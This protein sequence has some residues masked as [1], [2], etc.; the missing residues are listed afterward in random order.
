M[1]MDSNSVDRV[2]ASCASVG[3][4]PIFS[5]ASTVTLDRHRSDPNLNGAVLPLPEFP[6][7]LSSSPAIQEF[8]TTVARYAPGLGVSGSSENGWVS[9]KLFERAASHHLSATPTSQDILGGLAA[10]HEER[11]GGLSEPLTFTAGHN[12]PPT[13][14]WFNAGIANG[15]WSTPDNGQM[16]C[17]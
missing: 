15:N 16:H 1:A 12:A 13:E 4:H 6:W 9:A 11:L 14:C 7:F 8:Q 10:I 2:A 17:R 3:L 5:W